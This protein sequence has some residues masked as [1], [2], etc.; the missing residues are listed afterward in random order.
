MSECFDNL[1]NIRI[2][3]ITS[4]HSNASARV[5]INRNFKQIFDAIVC[6]SN[7]TLADIGGLILPDPPQN[8]VI[9]NIQF[10]GSNYVLVESDTNP[11]TK[12]IIREGE[13]IKV[14]EDYQYIVHDYLYLFGTIDIDGELVIL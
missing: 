5:I 1:G 3:Q 6:I 2:D 11:G 14:L 7:I 9:Y 12:Y 4:L 8:G 13:N 10:D